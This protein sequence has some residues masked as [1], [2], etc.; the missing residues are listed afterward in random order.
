MKL[1]NK[2]KKAYYEYQINEK[3][4]G[5][6]Q[7]TGSEIKPVRNHEVSISESYC[8]VKDGEVFVKNMYIKPNERSNNHDNHE[9]YRERR[10]LLN[11]KEIIKL[12][13]SVASKG[14]TLIV[15]DIHE[16]GTGLIKLTLGLCKGKKLHDKR[17]TIK[18]RDLDRDLKRKYK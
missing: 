14:M 2:N 3:Y 4:I 8:Y 9:P 10:L 17:N 6:I 15:L 1:I 16:T 13:S 7:L 5:G 18:E 12:E 11:K